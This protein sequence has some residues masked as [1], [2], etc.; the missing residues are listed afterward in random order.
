MIIG[1]TIVIKYLQDNPEVILEQK[2]EAGEI[3]D[4]EN[5]EVQKVTDFGKFYTV[6]NCVNTYID[7]IN[8]NNSSYYGTDENDNYTIIVSKENINKNIYDL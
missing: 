6:I 1:I 4:Y 2:G 8:I 7:K 5:Q 3:I